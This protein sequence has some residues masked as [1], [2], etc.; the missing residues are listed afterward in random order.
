[1]W[2]GQS[3][4]QA[5]PC[6][7]HDRITS[8][9]PPNA[10]VAVRI[11]VCLQCVFALQQN[12]TTINTMFWSALSQSAVWICTS[13]LQNFRRKSNLRSNFWIRSFQLLYW[14]LVMETGW[15]PLGWGWLSGH[16]IYIYYTTRLYDYTVYNQLKTSD[17][18]TGSKKNDQFVRISFTRSSRLS[19]PTLDHKKNVQTLNITCH[20]IYR[21]LGNTA[22]TTQQWNCGI[23]WCHLPQVSFSIKTLRRLHFLYLHRSLRSMSTKSPWF[24]S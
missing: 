12:K 23:I 11:G 14:T 7:E 15:E 3:T 2:L 21:N 19:L 5:K 24:R 10:A 8:A 9:A 6:W 16:H 4:F 17:S 1:M 18:L 22:S 20:A 13:R